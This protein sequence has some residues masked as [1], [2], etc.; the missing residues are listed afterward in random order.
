MGEN[1]QYHSLVSLVEVPYEERDVF[2]AY[3]AF[4][5]EE[6]RDDIVALFNVHKYSIGR[7]FSASSRRF[8]D[9]SVMVSPAPEPTSILWENSYVHSNCKLEWIFFQ[10]LTDIFHE[11]W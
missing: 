8:Y 9:H 7:R 5:T 3:V 10:I 11:N 4:D 2:R 6:L 1:I